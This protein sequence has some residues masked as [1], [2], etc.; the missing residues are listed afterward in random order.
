[1]INDEIKS[2]WLKIINFN[3]RLESLEQV[4][5]SE[6]RITLPI[7]NLEIPASILHYYTAILYPKFVNDQQNILD[8]IISR[9]RKQILKIFLYETRKAGVIERLEKIPNNVIVFQARD[10]ENIEELFNKLQLILIERK[11]V[12]INSM[13]IFYE[14]FIDLLN[15]YCLNTE[16]PSLFETT[17][18]FCEFVQKVT[19]DEMFYIFPE[20]NTYSF[21]NKLMNLM[22]GI[23]L[24][25]LCKNIYELLPESRFALVI[26]SQKSY[27]IIKLQKKA[28]RDLNSS[29]SMEIN[30]LE[31]MLKNP[32]ELPI[33]E[34]LRIIR[35]SAKLETLF[36]VNEDD[37]IHLFSEAVELEL[38]NNAEK[39]QLVL[40]KALYG[41]RSFEKK[42]YSFPRPIVY[43]NLVRFLIRI[44][45]I[46]LNLKN[47]S[48]WAIPDLIY[49]S[50]NA[51]F[52][53][54][55]KLLLI[56]TD[57]HNFQNLNP[58]DTNYL[59]LGNKFVYLLEIENG[60]L[61]RIVPLKFNDIVSSS[62]KT[63]LK[64][65]Q[66]YVS[67]QYGYISAVINV[68]KY[69]LSEY[70]KYFV[71]NISSI[72]L[73]KKLLVFRLI[74]KPYYFDMYPELPAYKL[75]KKTNIIKLLKLML[76]IIIDKHE[77]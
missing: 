18:N 35:T 41:Y 49:T 69:L 16:K 63:S 32:S 9:D 23:S 38:M 31:D 8:I 68:D 46:N 43:N 54:H 44:F 25:N 72:N 33:K 36:Y 28:A 58:K 75:M 52:G 67:S 14:E 6:E 34:I 20:P 77:F 39:A 37:L 62:E 60:T 40:Q 13:R 61:Y 24:K 48:H 12:K 71:W 73:I 5:L 19:D 17:L 66:N 27:W 76:P 3:A 42:W 50:F 53:L 10:L 64:L 1:M 55:S 7:L 21:I 74:R 70:F 15:K 29:F 45:G 47:L 65:I 26:G 4:P 59:K 22:K 57:L 56:I 30:F 2:I 11:G 51:Q